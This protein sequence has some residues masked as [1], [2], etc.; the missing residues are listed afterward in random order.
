MKTIKV[1]GLDQVSPESQLLFA[2]IKKQLGK[3]PNLYA[4]MGYSAST[5]AGFLGFDSALTKSV[6][7]SKERE[8]INLVVSEVNSCNY[9]LAAHTMIASTKGFSEKDILLFRKGDATDDKLKT[10]L[11]LTKSITENRGEADESLLNDFFNVG[12]DERALIDLIGLI[13]AKIFTNYVYSLT[14]VPIDFPEAMA[15][16]EA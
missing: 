14:K 12:Y 16:S 9:C 5:L 13:T 2:Q 3:V 10:V 8:A 6:F 1:P 15:L 11:L 7:N 4:T